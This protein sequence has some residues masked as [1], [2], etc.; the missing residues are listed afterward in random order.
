MD[1]SDA[2]LGNNTVQAKLSTLA[3]HQGLLPW[4]VNSRICMLKLIYFCMLELTSIC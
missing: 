2:A 4:C 3:D 1:L